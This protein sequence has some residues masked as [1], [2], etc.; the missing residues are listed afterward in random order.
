ME[1]SCWFLEDIIDY[2]GI[3]PPALLNGEQSLHSYTELLNSDQSW[4]VG[5][6][7]WSVERLG[8]LA[9][10]FLAQSQLQRLDVAVIGR[11]SQDWGSWQE[12]RLADTADMNAFLARASN[13]S[14]AT[15]ESRLPDVARAKDAL[16]AL[17]SFS[18][19]SDIFIELPWDRP[20]EDA[21]AEIADMDWA[22]VK[23]RTGGEIIPS[24]QQ[25]A[26]VIK[27]C[28]DLEIE[29][30]L[31]AGLHEP[32]AHT[33]PET[34]AWIHGFLNVLMA[35]SLAYHHDA[36]NA[37]IAEVLRSDEGWRVGKTLQW[38]DY[39]MDSAQLDDV[40]SFFSSFGSCSVSEPLK[41]LAKMGG[42]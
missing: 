22:R 6:L 37:E 29:F 30:K 26:N 7:V 1:R 9:E 14:I 24:A 10:L 32:I 36:S 2:A 19:E 25:L 18:N 38:G 3:F 13:A 34:G 31:T 16:Y 39:T 27:Q 23:F 33:D 8:E 21:L 42:F 28:V 40:R 11:A 41:G 35:T 12:A 15:Y 4:I 17:K 20:L 5:Y